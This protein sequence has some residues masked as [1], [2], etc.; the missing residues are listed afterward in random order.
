MKIKTNIAIAVVMIAMGLP[1]G[2]AA[3]PSMAGPD[4]IS[5]QWKGQ[6]EV[7]GYSAEVTLNLKL[8]GTQV[9]GTADSEHT[10]AG[11]LSKGSWAN[12]KLSFTMDFAAHESIA[13]TA[14]LKDG[15]LTGEFRTEGMQGT[16][17]AR[18]K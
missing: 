1:T 13:A 11:T 16:W 10:G 8:K 3:A 18:R 7:S 15:K 9:V 4:P 14:V 12:N 17:E 2:L 6:F 5:G